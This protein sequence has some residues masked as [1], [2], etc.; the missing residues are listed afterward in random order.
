MILSTIAASISAVR[1]LPAATPSQGASAAR[2]A[3][4][5]GS[6][7]ARAHHGGHG[8]DAPAPTSTPSTVEQSSSSLLNTLA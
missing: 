1:P 6:Q 2:P 3:S 4:S 7:P 5:T 8:R